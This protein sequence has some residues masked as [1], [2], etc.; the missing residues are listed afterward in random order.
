MRNVFVLA[1][2]SV[3]LVGW[4]VAWLAA[5]SELSANRVPNSFLLIWLSIWTAGGGFALFAVLWAL[6]GREVIT[7]APSSLVLE[8]RIGSLGRARR[9]DTT[10]IRDLR[11]SAQP[12]RPFDRRSGLWFW[13]I[14]GGWIAFD[15][16][17]ST[18]RFAAGLEEAE[19]KQVVGRLLE[20]VPSIGPQQRAQQHPTGANP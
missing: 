11:V 1:V 19:A 17:A 20:C 16:G 12:Y 13:G 3:W 2:L 7:A 14:S 5:V 4:L 9:Y 10:R 15:Y 6:V 18:I 8:R